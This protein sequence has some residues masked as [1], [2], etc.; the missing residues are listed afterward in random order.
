MRCKLYQTE[1]TFPKCLADFVV[2]VY[3]TIAHGYLET[4]I[5]QLKLFLVFEVDYARLVWRQHDF[6]WVVSFAIFR[7]SF[8]RNVFNKSSREAVHH[9]VFLVLFMPVNEDF[10]ADNSGPVSL[11][12]IRSGF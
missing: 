3:V 10:F 7:V 11:K 8:S 2:V 12:L 4:F 5:P 6:D 1:L 9:T